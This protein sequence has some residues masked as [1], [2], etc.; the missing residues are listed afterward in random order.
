MKQ[1]VV[2]RTDLDGNHPDYVALGWSESE[3]HGY[4][5]FGRYRWLALWRMRFGIW[6]HEHGWPEP[7]RRGWLHRVLAGKWSQ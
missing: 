4:R 6:R 1:G 7:D 5:A 3:D 2:R